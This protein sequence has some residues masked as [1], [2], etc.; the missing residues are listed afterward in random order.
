MASQ[1]LPIPPYQEQFGRM[2]DQV[3]DYAII[4]LDPKG[5]VLSWNAGAERAKGYRAE[6]IVGQHF[7][8]FYPEEAVLRGWPQEEL[9]IS[10]EHGRFEDEGWRI[11]KDGTTFWANVVITPW[12]DDAGRLQ[13]YLKITRDLTARKQAEDR[14]TDFAR[15]LERSNRELEQF[16]SVAAHDLQEPLR[17]IQAFSDRLEKQATNLDDQSRDYLRRMIGAVGR[18]RD[19]INALLTFSRVTT[20]AQAFSDVDLAQVASEIVSDVE[21]RIQQTGGRVE[22]GALPV[23][24]ADPLQ[25]RQLLLNLTANALKFR[26]PEEAPVVRIE[27]EEQDGTIKLKVSDNGIGFEEI[28]LDRIFDVFQRLHG[29]QEYE[30]T[31]MGLAICRKIVERH[32]GTISAQSKPGEGA[33]F[34]VSLPRKQTQEGQPN[35]SQI[36]HYPHGR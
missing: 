1:P 34:I 20:K 15:R 8:K 10:L 12:R 24:E 6:E 21:G 16:A 33:T 7:S 27:A 36:D 13:G 23:I 2:V 5:V 28:Y 11:R 9:K 3:Q 17:K 29:R 19:L 22:I 25:M 18:M 32:Q 26:R 30:G 14:L 35:G 31:G 4:M